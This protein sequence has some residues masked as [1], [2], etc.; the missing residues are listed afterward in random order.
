MQE[1]IANLYQFFYR[2]SLL[3]S[4]ES[5]VVLTQFYA[6]FVYQKLISTLI[7]STLSFI[8]KLFVQI[9]TEISEGKFHGVFHVRDTI[10]YLDTT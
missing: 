2:V 6:D 10:L 4:F 1:N 9:I 5:K 8:S 7:G 3:L